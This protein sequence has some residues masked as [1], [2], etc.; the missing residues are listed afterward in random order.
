MT[1]PGRSP[2]TAAPVP[3]APKASSISATGNSGNVWSALNV[4]CR[5]TQ[6]RLGN[7]THMAWFQLVYSVLND[8]T[9]FQKAIL[10][11]IVKIRASYYSQQLFHHVFGSLAKNGSM[12]KL[13]RAFSFRSLHAANSLPVQLFYFKEIKAMKINNYHQINH[14]QASSKILIRRMLYRF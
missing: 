11:I 7:D 8:D 12:M 2:G 4:Q 3:S 6:C 1:R 9:L 14:E 5:S 13:R 10:C